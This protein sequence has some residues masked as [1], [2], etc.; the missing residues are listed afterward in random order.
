MECPHPPSPPP[1]LLPL[2]LNSWPHSLL[3][4]AVPHT[5][6]ALPD[7]L[8]VVSSFARPCILVARD[9]PVLL[10]PSPIPWAPKLPVEQGKVDV[11]TLLVPSWS[12][13]N[14][15]ECGCFTKSW[16]TQLQS[17]AYHSQCQ[18]RC[19]LFHQESP[20]GL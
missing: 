2:F 14:L 1:N 20:E 9:A 6:H 7:C 4:S 13:G 15:A 18:V 10:I 16:C 5:C 8:L 17:S 3:S 12:R 11:N 19:S